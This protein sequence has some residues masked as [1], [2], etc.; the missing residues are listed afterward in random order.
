[1]LLKQTQFLVQN[2]HVNTNYLNYLKNESNITNNELIEYLDQN[3][4]LK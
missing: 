2:I 4:N 3:K 1:M